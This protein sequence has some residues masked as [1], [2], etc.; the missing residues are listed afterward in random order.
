M[1]SGRT[2]QSAIWKNQAV[3]SGRT[4]QCHLEESD[5]QSAIWKNQAE[6]HL[7]EPGRVPSGRTRQSAIWKNQAE[8][9]LEEPGRVPSGRTR[10][11]AIWKNQAEC[12][13]EELLH[14][15]GHLFRLQD[16][17]LHI[18]YPPPKILDWIQ[19]VGRS[20]CHINLQPTRF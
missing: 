10:Q 17:L 12:H 18:G 6:C 14:R 3:P 13:L 4:T 7:E 1:P 19:S 9:H 15:T 16:T 2:R 11:S 20:H 8:C 5:R